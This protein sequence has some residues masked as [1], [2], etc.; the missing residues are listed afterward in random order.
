MQEGYGA[1]LPRREVAIF[2]ASP[3][4]KTDTGKRSTPTA[5]KAGSERQRAIRRGVE[6]RE[7]TADEGARSAH[8]PGRHVRAVQAR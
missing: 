1:V 3:D 5:C 7:E 8:G 6:V 2:M 4:L